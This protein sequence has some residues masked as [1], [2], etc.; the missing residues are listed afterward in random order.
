[1]SPELNS[2]FV[3]GLVVCPTTVISHWMNKIGEHAPSLKPTPYHGGERDLRS[4]LKRAR[5]LITSYGV[6]RNDIVPLSGIRL[7]LDGFGGA[8]RRSASEKIF[9]REELIDLL[10]PL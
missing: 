4:A 10:R 8:T 5:V 1:M 3:H 7:P 2:S 9:T 6:L